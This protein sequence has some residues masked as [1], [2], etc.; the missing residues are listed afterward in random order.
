M[1]DLPLPCARN[2][3]KPPVSYFVAAP[4]TPPGTRPPILH[5]RI[6]N[7]RRLDVPC[8]LNVGIRRVTAGQFPLGWAGSGSEDFALSLVGDDRNRKSFS[9]GDLRAIA[10]MPVCIGGRGLL[11]LREIVPSVHLQHFVAVGVDDLHGA[12]LGARGTAGF[13][14]Y[15]A[16]TRRLRDV[17]G[18]FDPLA[19]GRR[20]TRLSRSGLFQCSSS[21]CVARVG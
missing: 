9:Q 17:Y 20:K 10:R 3:Q 7:V 14:S 18:R 19:T 21:H 5:F 8:D 1:P 16:R 13:W 12:L 2:F 11:R 4:R 6:P 15:R